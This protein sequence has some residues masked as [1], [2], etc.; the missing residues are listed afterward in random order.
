MP[1]TRSARNRNAA[2]EAAAAAAASVATVAPAPAP[3]T[4]AA[5]APVQYPLYVV[6]VESESLDDSISGPY[7]VERLGVKSILAQLLRADQRDISFPRPNDERSRHM[8]LVRR[9]MKMGFSLTYSDYKFACA[10]DRDTTVMAINTLMATKRCF[11]DGDMMSECYTITDMSPSWLDSGWSDNDMDD[12][13]DSDDSDSDDSDSDDGRDSETSLGQYNDAVTRGRYEDDT[14][15]YSDEVGE[16]PEAVTA[17]HNTSSNS[18][19]ADGTT[20]FDEL[21]R[22]PLA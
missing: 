19:S 22:A 4:A 14:T 6:E 12:D 10:Q 21:L 16:S 20:E 8:Q 17:L 1:T 7:V 9:W 3:T 5:A 2:L 13:S 15:T 18:S 11:V